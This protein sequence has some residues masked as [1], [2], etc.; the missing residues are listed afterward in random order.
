VARRGGWLPGKPAVALAAVLGV[1]AASGGAGILA[2]FAKPATHHGVPAVL[3]DRVPGLPHGHDVTGLPYSALF[4]A[5]GHRHGIAPTLL[6]AV[7]TQESG[8][9]RRAVSGAGALGLMQFM[10]ATA[11]GLGVDPMDP[12]SAIDGAARLLVG[13]TREF[14]SVPLALAAYN[15][16]GPAVRKYHGIPPYAET[17][18]YVRS[19]LAIQARYERGDY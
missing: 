4:N 16:G 12:A 3:G 9:N 11:A 8:F 15:A 18:R 7:A 13:L 2:G 19:V 1:G 5:A 10:P 14:G 17:Q 6:A